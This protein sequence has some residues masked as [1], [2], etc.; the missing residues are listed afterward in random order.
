MLRRSGTSYPNPLVIL[1][2]RGLYGMSKAAAEAG[3]RTLARDSAMNISVI[4]PP[5][6]Y[7]ADGSGV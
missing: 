7:G 2:P 4:R 6:I 1:T 3:L 5:L